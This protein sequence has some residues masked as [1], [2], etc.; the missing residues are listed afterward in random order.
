MSAE[1]NIK[2]NRSSR[3]ALLAAIGVIAMVGLYRWILW[4][5]SNQLFAAQRHESAL[6][7]NIQKA[8]SL[9]S[10][11]E[12]KKAKIE[13]MSKEADLLRNE[14]FTVDEARAFFA[15]LGAIGSQT[16]CVIQSVSLPAGQRGGQQGAGEPESDGSGIVCKKAMVTVAGGYNDIVRFLDKIMG[17][18]HRVWIESVNIDIGGNTG[19]LKCQALLTLYCIER[20]ESNSYE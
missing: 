19:K 7:K 17:W 13:Q 20:M 4:P 2:L 1:K 18:Q 5:Y 3:R 12:A 16:G 11:I 14:L 15:S 9:N 6:D 8:N 10:T